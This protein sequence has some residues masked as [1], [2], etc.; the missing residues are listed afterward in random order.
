MS[1]QE[2]LRFEAPPEDHYAAQHRE[3]RSAPLQESEVAEWLVRG[4]VWML[5]ACAEAR[6][7]EALMAKAVARS[8]EKLGLT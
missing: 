6:A 3:M 5:A 4:L 7:E 2:S 1:E 8:R